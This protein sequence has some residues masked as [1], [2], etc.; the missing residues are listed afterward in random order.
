MSLVLVAATENFIIFMSDGRAQYK[1][2]EVIVSKEENYKKLKPIN[3]HICLGY[4]GSKE[5]CEQALNEVYNPHN[6]NSCN[7]LSNNIDEISN[8]LAISSKKIFSESNRL[9]KAIS[10]VI[11]GISQMGYIEF[12]TF[13]S[14]YNFAIERYKPNNGD[15]VYTALHSDKL[16]E[17]E[18]KAKF[19]G[20]LL[21]NAPINKNSIKKAM[22]DC[23]D[24][25]S[26]LDSSVN[27]NKFMEEIQFDYNW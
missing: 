7:P 8:A 19:E 12:Y 13:A 20:H 5:L 11:G 27:K 21:S 26:S 22:E 24:E 23:I 4:T 1:V 15:L 25:V 18:M 14:K 16:S 6:P 2:N 3:Q 9:D 10:F 17:A